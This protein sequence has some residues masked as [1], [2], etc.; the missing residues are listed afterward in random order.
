MSSGIIQEIKSEL[1]IEEFTAPSQLVELHSVL[2]NKASMLDKMLEDPNITDEQK[3]E[4]ESQLNEITVRSNQIRKM[5]ADGISEELSSEEAQLMDEWRQENPTGFA[6][7][8]EEVTKMLLDIKKVRA[9]RH[10]FI[11]LYNELTGIETAKPKIQLMENAIQDIRK[12]DS[13]DQIE[14]AE[15]KRLYLRYAG[16][17]LEFDYTTK[18]GT[19]KKYRVRMEKELD[20]DSNPILTKIPT[21]EDAYKYKLA[22]EIKIL[23]GKEDEYS[24]KRIQELQDK[25]AEMGNP[26][27]TYKA[28]FL[29]SAKNIKLISGSEILLERVHYISEMMRG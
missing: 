23:E 6:K 19:I 4:I 10:A 5:A 21:I 22:E 25:M 17:I 18:D 28:D 24:K 16:E 2:A 15:M 3:A 12:E 8:S 29:K 1:G 26:K 20:S 7:D 13:Y 9:R 14:D 11:D 27:Q